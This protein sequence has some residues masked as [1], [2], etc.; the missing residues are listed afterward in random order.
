MLTEAEVV[1]SPIL[2]VSGVMWHN[3]ATKATMG[4]SRPV[5]LPANPGSCEPGQ[6]S[7]PNILPEL[8]TEIGQVGLDMPEEHRLLDQRRAE[9]RG[10]GA[11]LRYQ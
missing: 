3:P 4:T 8:Q 5:H 10:D 2:H 11:V 7:G 9:S 1:D 6:H